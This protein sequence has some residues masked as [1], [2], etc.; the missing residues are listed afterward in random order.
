MMDY[1]CIKVAHTYI[2]RYISNNHVI[3]QHL[4]YR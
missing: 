1:F 3:A 4:E 2:I